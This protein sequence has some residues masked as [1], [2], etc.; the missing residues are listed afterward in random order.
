MKRESFQPAASFDEI[1]QALG[2]TRGG[3]WMLYRSA[4]SKLRRRPEK[5]RKLRELVE[6]RTS[7]A[8]GAVLG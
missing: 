2:I 4:I 8:R 5:L 3:A 6:L 7:K 1:G